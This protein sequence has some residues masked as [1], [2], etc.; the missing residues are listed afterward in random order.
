MTYPVIFTRQAIRELEDAVDWWAEHR[1]ADQANRWYIGFREKIASLSEDPE[2]FPWAE[3][4]DDFPYEIREL[5][6]GLSSRPSHRAVF[7]ITDE[8][9]VVLTIR[10]V[11]R[12]RLT[13]DEVSEPPGNS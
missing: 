2:R 7:V 3:E 6:Y 8:N 5:Y 9:V 10:H 1:N 11:A 12:D 13:L 4:N